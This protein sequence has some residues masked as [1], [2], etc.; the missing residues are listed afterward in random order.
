MVGSFTTEEALAV[1]G[2]GLVSIPSSAKPGVL[3]DVTRSEESKPLP[4]FE[5]LAMLFGVYA[6]SLDGRIAILVSDTVRFGIARQFSSIIER[7]GLEASPFGN[8]G[9]ALDWLDATD[10]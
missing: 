10:R 3:I 5:R 2:R 8:R 9:T 4:D 7:Y 6:G 1:F